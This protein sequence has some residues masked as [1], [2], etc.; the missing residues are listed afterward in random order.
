MSGHPR[1]P[2]ARCLLPIQRRRGDGGGMLC[3]RERAAGGLGMGRGKASQEQRIDGGKGGGCPVGGEELGGASCSFL[4]PIDGRFGRCLHVQA[5]HFPRQ[6]L[7]R[8]VPHVP[9]QAR[10]PRYITGD[11]GARSSWAAM[12]YSTAG[13]LRGPGGGRCHFIRRPCPE[14]RG[15]PVLPPAPSRSPHPDDKL[16]AATRAGD[17]RRCSLQHPPSAQMPRFPY[18]LSLFSAPS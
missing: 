3:G 7:I 9:L 5:P 1:A 6:P 15:W 12:R 10:N 16:A 14:G 11:V 4:K 8:A 13:A 18:I 2:A 17:S